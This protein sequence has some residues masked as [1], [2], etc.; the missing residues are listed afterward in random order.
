M[1]F[2]EKTLSSEKIY[3]GKIINVRVDTVELPEHKYQKREIV[4]HNGGVT[5]AAY[6]ENKKILIV[7][8][9]R[10]P[11]EDVLWELPAGKLEFGEDPKSCAIRELKE[12]T[13]Y[14]AANVKHLSSFYTSPGFCT[15]I[16]HLFMATDLTK[17]ELQLDEDEYVECF[18]FTFEEA[19]SMIKSGQIK[20]SKS[21]TGILLLKEMI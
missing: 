8:Q 11:A 2:E 12:E 1:I 17:G 7:K 13:G 19:I 18:E 4:E 5:V 20:D 15:E 14:Q 3:N 16:I 6:T 21:I 9:F 10:K